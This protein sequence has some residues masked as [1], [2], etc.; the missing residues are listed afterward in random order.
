L[1][2]TNPPPELIELL[3]N[4]KH[5]TKDTPPCFLFHTAEDKVVPVQNSLMFA[6]AL[7]K[8]KVPFDL[9]IFEKGGHGGGL[10]GYSRSSYD[11]ARMHPW[12]S[13]CLFWLK[14]QGWAK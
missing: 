10:G 8:A 9:H 12:T 11:P 2:G 3:S 7:A 4:E 6:M 5:V 14:Q 13:D 1:L